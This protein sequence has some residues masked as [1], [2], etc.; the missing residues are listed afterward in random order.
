MAAEIYFKK[1]P[2]SMSRYIKWQYY[3]ITEF[4]EQILSDIKSVIEGQ[5]VL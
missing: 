2:F 3:K 1:L 4:A 5:T